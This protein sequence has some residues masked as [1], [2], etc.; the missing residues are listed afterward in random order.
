MF[1]WLCC[2]QNVEKR[3]IFEKILPEKYQYR[4]STFKV[5]EE[6]DIDHETKFEAVLAVNIC[7]VDN[8]E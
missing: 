4:I 2:N 1:S 8:I 6:S 7:S 5:I 3:Q